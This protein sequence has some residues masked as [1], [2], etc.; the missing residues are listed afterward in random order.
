MSNCHDNTLEELDK[1]WK[2]QKLFNSNFVDFSSLTDSEKQ[3]MTKEYVLHLLSEANSLLETI[4]WKMHH[5]KDLKVNRSDVILEII[6]VWK[7]LLS[8]GLIWD[9]TP[10]EF[11]RVYDEKSQLVEQRFL[12]EF[13][14]N[15]QKD[16]IICDIDGIIG[17]YPK[18]FLRYVKNRARGSHIDVEDFDE[19]KVDNLDLYE[20]LGKRGYDLNFVS[21]CKH[22][23][24]SSGRSREE[25]VIQETSEFLQM[26]KNAGYYIV[27]LT[28]RPFDLYKNLYL[29]TYVWLESNKVPFDMLI[30]DSKKRNKVSRLLDTYSIKFILDDDPK[31]VSSLKGLS[32]RGK[33]VLFLLDKPYNQSYEC[34][35]K[36]VIRV[37][38]LNEICEHL[39]I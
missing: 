35:G 24:R 26:M 18:S 2:V 36:S 16:I 19:D 14:Q 6:D 1:M 22:L 5:K 29:D 37:K 21:Q 30:N 11:L 39:S 15:S 10:E 3:E 9:L 20:F 23:Y 27:L 12:Q 8:I 17:D 13:G 4:N 38:S 32:D 34:D 25:S 7:Y 31:V 28:S 33:T